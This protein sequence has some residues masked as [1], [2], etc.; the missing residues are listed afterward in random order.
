I[1]VGMRKDVARLLSASDVF[2]LPTLTEA[3]PTVLAEAMAARLPI[4]ASRVGGIPEMVTD[5]QNGCLVAPGKLDELVSAC[6]QLLADQDARTA[7][8]EEGWRTVD[9][10]FNIER[11]VDKLEEL[12]VDQ[13][14]AHGK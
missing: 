3:L 1:F 7:M 8:G 10:K 9:Q 13:L 12:Y 11:Q 6:S 5:E 14:R 2:V 4:V